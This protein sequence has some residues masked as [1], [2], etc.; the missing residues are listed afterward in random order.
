MRPPQR[1]PPLAYVP[2]RP[3][4]LPLAWPALRETDRRRTKQ[5]IQEAGRLPGPRLLLQAVE[6]RADASEQAHRHC[7]LPRRE[8]D[9][10]RPRRAAIELEQGQVLLCPGLRGR[11]LDGED[12]PG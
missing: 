11:A 8:R 1:L 6:G 12:A 7:R 10:M 9:S 5:H 3:C 2:E 4:D